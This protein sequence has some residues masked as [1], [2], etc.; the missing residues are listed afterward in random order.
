MV[1]AL[2]ALGRYS[3]ERLLIVDLGAAIALASLARF[4]LRLGSAARRVPDWEALIPVA[5][6][7]SCDVAVL[8]TVGIHHRRQ[9]SGRVHQRRRPDRAARRAVRTRSGDRLRPQLR[10]RPLLSV[11]APHRL[12]QRPLHGF[13]HPGAGAGTRRRAVPAPLPGIDCDRLRPRRVDGSQAGDRPVGRP[14]RARG[15]FRGCT[16]RRARSRRQLRP[17]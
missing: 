1:L 6:L 2:A 8:S 10:A 14:R 9:G 17:V 5:L 3:F 15:L 13:F 11:G 7:C 4:R 12:L 16:V